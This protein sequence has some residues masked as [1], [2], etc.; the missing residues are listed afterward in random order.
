LPGACNRPVRRP[1]SGKAAVEKTGTPLPDALVASLRRTRVG[2]KGPLETQVGVGYRSLN[3]L[4]RKTFDLYAN[5]RLVRSLP[6]V[7]AA[8]PGG[9][10]DRR[11]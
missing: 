10:P 5:V 2:L 7:R 1:S 4:L 8:F 9:G 6:G 11:P 3:A